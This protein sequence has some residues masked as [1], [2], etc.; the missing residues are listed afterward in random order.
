MLLL[1]SPLN[2]ENFRCRCGSLLPCNKQ[3]VISLCAVSSFLNCLL[4]RNF[5]LLLNVSL[6]IST[7]CV[8]RS[9]LYV[10]GIII[11]IISNHNQ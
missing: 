2:C 8:P 4:W 1:L 9:T 7:A 6:Y 11:I 3:Q 10:E 5:F